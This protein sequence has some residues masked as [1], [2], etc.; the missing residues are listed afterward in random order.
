MT[1]TFHAESL[2]AVAAARAAGETPARWTLTSA[3]YEH[4][5]SE[6]DR[7]AWRIHARAAELGRETPRPWLGLPVEIKP[8][9]H[10]GWTL[11]TESGQFWDRGGRIVY[12]VPPARS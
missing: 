2:A 6:L 11:H 8:G 9:A 12:S 4:L 3:L 10:H 1:A 7:N 5:E